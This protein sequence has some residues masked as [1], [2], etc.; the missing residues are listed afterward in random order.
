VQNRKEQNSAERN[1]RYYPKFPT[2]MASLYSSIFSS[3]FRSRPCASNFL[4][5]YCGLFRGSHVEK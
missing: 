5:H 2:C 3:I 1:Q 4:W